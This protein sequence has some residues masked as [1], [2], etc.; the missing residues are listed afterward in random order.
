MTTRAVQSARLRAERHEGI[1]INTFAQQKKD[2]GMSGVY[3]FRVF[4]L[5]GGDG[6]KIE[7]YDVSNITQIL[8][9]SQTSLFFSR[10]KRRKMSGRSCFENGGKCNGGRLCNILK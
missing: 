3:E 5:Q 1:K 2:S 8:P 7:V 9:R 6:I 4:P 10:G